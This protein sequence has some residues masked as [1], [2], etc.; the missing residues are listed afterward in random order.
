MKIKVKLNNDWY[1]PTKNK[2]NVGGQFPI[3]GRLYRKG[4][5]E[6]DES[7]IKVLPKSAEIIDDKYEADLVE[8]TVDNLTHTTYRTYDH[9]RAALEQVEE[10]VKRKPG[11]P[12]KDAA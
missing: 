5:H 1:A 11:R 10:H 7:L 9:E 6:L 3:C 4:V 8:E 12:K 2:V